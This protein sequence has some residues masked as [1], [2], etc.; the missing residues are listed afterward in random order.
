MTARVVYRDSEM[1]LRVE[2]L[3]LAAQRKFYYIRSGLAA[4]EVL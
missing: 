2:L 4:S 1:P 3:Q